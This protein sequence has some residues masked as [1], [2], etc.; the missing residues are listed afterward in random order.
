MNANFA[1]KSRRGP[2]DSEGKR[3]TTADELGEIRVRDDKT[4]KLLITLTGDEATV[5]SAAVSAKA[6]CIASGDEHV[7]LWDLDDAF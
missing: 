4:G 1:E 3:L 2:A 5:R 7:V 6:K